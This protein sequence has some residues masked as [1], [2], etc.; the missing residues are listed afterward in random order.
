MVCYD[1]KI[2]LIT[3]CSSGIGY[4]AAIALKDRGYRVIASCRKNADVAKLS[5]LGLE[6]IQLDVN[7]SV[8]INSAFAQLMELTS[9]HIDVLINNAGYGQA[10][11][12]EDITRDVIRQQFETNVFGLLE[13]TNLVI[14]VMRKQG[15]GLI[16]NVSSILGIISLPFRGAYNASK[17]ALEGLS[18]TLRLELKSAGIKVVTIEPGPIQSRFRDNLIDGTLK[19]INMNDSHY[20]QQYQAMLST[21]QQ[22]TESVF[23]KTTQ[24]VIKKLEHA[25]ES[26]KPKAR[27][28]VTL[29]AHLFIFLKRIL[30]CSLLDKLFLLISKQELSASAAQKK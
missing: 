29:P 22:K 15:D 8:S 10:G 19:N 13:L 4:D 9:G 30:S 12:L 16:I 1:K 23:T 11:A 3:G 6:S 14:P 26:S 5:A 17:Y 21:Y 7:D 24:A 27:Y 2:I 25:I 28:P 20:S 18:D